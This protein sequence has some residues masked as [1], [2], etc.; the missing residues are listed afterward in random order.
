MRS[1]FV[2]ITWASTSAMTSPCLRPAF[3]AGD[4]LDG[5]HDDPIRALQTER[6]LIALVDRSDG[7]A[8]IAAHDFA[9]LQLG[10]KLLSDVDRN[11]E[12]DV[13]REPGD[14]R[15]DSD[16]L[17]LDVDE[18]P[19]GIA[20]VDRRVGLDEVLEALCC[21]GRVG[22][23]ALPPDHSNGD[24]LL[25]LERVSD[26]DDPVAPAGDD[27]RYLSGPSGKAC[28]RRSS[29]ERASVAGS[30]PMTFAS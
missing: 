7:D 3:S 27:S 28:R 15:V 22:L 14:R 30:R 24:G 18:R 16:D 10:Q 25:E 8:E 17:G 26:R 21:A 9:N 20:E 11:G 23:P 19:A 4:S 6:F 29:R 1:R 2:L 12:P 5:L 13:L